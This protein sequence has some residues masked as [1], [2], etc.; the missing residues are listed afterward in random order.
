MFHLVNG[1]ASLEMGLGLVQ[2]QIQNLFSFIFKPSQLE[3]V[4][5]LQILPY[6]HVN[7]NSHSIRS[8]QIR[9]SRNLSDFSKQF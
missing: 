4:W 6:D 2:I 9:I 1:S 3:L 8:R 7:L 5:R